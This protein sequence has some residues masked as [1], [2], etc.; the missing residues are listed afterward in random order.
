MISPLPDEEF[1]IKRAIELYVAKKI[2]E[3]AGELTGRQV[4]AAHRCVVEKLCA[5]K[6]GWDALECIVDKMDEVY[7]KIK[8][9]G[10]ERAMA[11]YTCPTS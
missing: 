5:G 9:V 3:Y 7:R 6:A 2:A 8:E 10:F 1:L 11:E 4:R